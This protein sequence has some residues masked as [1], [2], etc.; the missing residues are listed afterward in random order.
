MLYTLTQ[1]QVDALRT[2]LSVA[3]ARS[4]TLL[5]SY[6]CD[7]LCARLSVDAQSTLA[8]FDDSI[9]DTAEA[10]DADDLVDVIAELQSRLPRGA[11]LSIQIPPVRHE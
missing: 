5:V 3:S 10:P 2:R 1:T 8:F 9:A 6:P 11:S 7:T 4:A